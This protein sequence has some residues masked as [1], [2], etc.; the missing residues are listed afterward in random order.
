[1]PPAQQEDFRRRHGEDWA[2]VVRNYF[3]IRNSQALQE[4]HNLEVLVSQIKCPVLVIRHDSL[5]DTTHPF[6]HAVELRTRLPQSHLAFVPSYPAGGAA[7]FDGSKLRQLILEFV[8]SLTP[9]P[10]RTR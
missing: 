3:N 8:E 4:Y 9:A 5:E 7:R 1:M 2:D 6:A 10:A